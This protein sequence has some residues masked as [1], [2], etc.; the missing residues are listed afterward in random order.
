[1]TTKDYAWKD[2]EL[3]LSDVRERPDFQVRLGGV[4]S[5]HVRVLERTLE[6]GG[7]LGPVKVARIGKALYL[8]DGFHR[9]EAARRA[10]RGTIGAKVARMSLKEAEAFALLANTRHGKNLT[11]ADKARLLALYVEQ[12]RHWG[13]D[14]RMK[15]SRVISAELNHVYS[16]E[17]IRTKLKRLGVEMDE[18]VEFPHGYRPMVREES[19]E[20]LEAERGDEAQRD[21]ERFAA[22][23]PT[24]EGDR[25]RKL[26]EAARAALESLERGEEPVWPWG[27]PGPLLDI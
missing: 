11:P 22:L 1:M 26:L 25:R 18:D 8:V 4:D 19:E 15:S 24:L 5:R 6:A 3:A 7:A 10:G 13:T 20:E 27:A 9:L 23:V 17:T 16:H 14:G 21:L 2:E 12:E